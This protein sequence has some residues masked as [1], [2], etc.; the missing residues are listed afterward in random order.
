MNSV[1]RVGGLAALLHATA[2][3]VAMALGIALIF[4]IMNSDKGQ[5]LAFITNNQTLMYL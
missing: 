2:Y 3:M 1:Q 5:Y 4:P